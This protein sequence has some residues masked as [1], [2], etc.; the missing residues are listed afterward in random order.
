MDIFNMPHFMGKAGA[1][2][3][4]ILGTIGLFNVFFPSFPIKLRV[5]QSMHKRFATLMERGSMP[6][7]FALGGLVGIFEFPCT[8]GAYLMILGLLHDAQTYWAGLWYL[9][10]YNAIF[11]S[12]LAAILFIASNKTLLEKM[13]TWRKEHSRD[14]RLWSSAAMILLGALIFLLY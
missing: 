10:F 13:N 9:L 3:L 2:L 4:V 8:G 7:A 12:P 1:V 6:S 5:P 14:M 11:V